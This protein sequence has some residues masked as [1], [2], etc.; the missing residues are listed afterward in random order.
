[1]PSLKCMLLYVLFLLSAYWIALYGGTLPLW[2]RTDFKFNLDEYKLSSITRIL[3]YIQGCNQVMD[4]ITVDKFTFHPLA[5]HCGYN[6]RHWLPFATQSA[7]KVC[8][9]STAY[10]QGP[11]LVLVPS[12]AVKVKVV[13]FPDYQRYCALLWWETSPFHQHNNNYL[14]S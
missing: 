4:I 9:T 5:S 1:M 8:C 7:L 11:V 14:H 12:L 10:I 6:K 13:R 2:S 3:V